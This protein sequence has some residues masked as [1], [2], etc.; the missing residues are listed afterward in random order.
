VERLLNPKAP[1]RLRRPRHREHLARGFTLI[2]L[3][4]VVVIVSVFAAMAIPQITVQ[5][6]DRRVHEAAQR[7]MLM[8]QEARSRAM[9]Q[10]GAVMVRYLSAGSG[11]FEIREALVGAAAPDH[12][13]NRPAVSCT[14]TNWDDTAPQQ[15]RSIETFNLG[16]LSIGV[17]GYSE[18]VTAT[19]TPDD[20]SA[21]GDS[22]DVC[23]TPMG[24]AFVRYTIGAGA[25]FTP[26]TGI[27]QVTVVRQVSSTPVGRA[28]VV[29]VLPTGVARLQ[30]RAP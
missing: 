4:V 18:L 26:L 2:E 16:E 28:R 8:Y 15:F 11:S 14:Q 29:L 5:L 13:I 25:P 20:V 7:V 30:D 10:G 17:S 12:C 24:R 19:L 1:R 23:F 9:G 22:M 27:P 21:S 6:R 3:V